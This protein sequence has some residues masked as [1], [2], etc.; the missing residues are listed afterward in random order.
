[1]AKNIKAILSDINYKETKP[2]YWAKP[3]AMA[4][5]VVREREDGQVDHCILFEGKDGKTYLWN[6]TTY[7]PENHGDILYNEFELGTQNI[8]YAPHWILPDNV[9]YS[10]CDDE[11]IVSEKL[12]YLS[13]ILEDELKEDCTKLYD[14]LYAILFDNAELYG[15]KLVLDDL[16][17]V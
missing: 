11:Y 10:A 9:N 6:R 3:L 4:L 16:L 5:S 12:D 14:E 13:C 7:S 17:E 8:L 15:L 2:G 1:M